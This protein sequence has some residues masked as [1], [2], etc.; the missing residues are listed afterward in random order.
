MKSKIAL[1]NLAGLVAANLNDIAE[2]I[3]APEVQKFRDA[4]QEADAALSEDFA[5]ASM[6]GTGASGDP[7]AGSLAGDLNM[8]PF[9]SH[10]LER[11]HAEL[12]RKAETDNT[13]AAIAD[14]TARAL[15]GIA[16]A[17][18]SAKHNQPATSEG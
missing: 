12:D 14:R 6:Y 16:E 10:L 5:D 11:V 9:V 8:P 15:E 17:M 7:A 4:L 3:P 18:N 1:M 2:R 13:M